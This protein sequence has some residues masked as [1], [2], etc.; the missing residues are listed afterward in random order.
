VDRYVAILRG[1]SELDL[2]AIAAALGPTTIRTMG[3][4]EQIAAKHLS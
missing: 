1:M 4:V 2:K 3:T